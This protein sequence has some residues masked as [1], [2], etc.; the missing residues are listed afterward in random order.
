M[1]PDRVVSV[2]VAL[3]YRRVQPVERIEIRTSQLALIDEWII[4]VSDS[5][6]REYYARNDMRRDR[7]QSVRNR[8]RMDRSIAD[9]ATP[10]YQIL[11]YYD[12]HL[13]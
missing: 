5:Q 3:Y 1:R 4:S 12:Y 13:S 7:V 2:R 10:N 11:S 6:K 8:T 9:R